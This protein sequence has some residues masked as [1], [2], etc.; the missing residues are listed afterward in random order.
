MPTTQ[1]PKITRAP[2]CPRLSV[3]RFGILSQVPSQA[4]IDQ[5]SLPIDPVNINAQHMSALPSLTGF[6]IGSTSVPR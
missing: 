2:I 6:K 3:G 5:N 4:S 1:R